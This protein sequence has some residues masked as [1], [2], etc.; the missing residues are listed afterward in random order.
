MPKKATTPIVTIS[1]HARDWRGIALAVSLDGAFLLHDVS[2][3]SVEGFIQAIRMRPYTVKRHKALRSLTMTAQTFAGNKQRTWVWWND[4]KV[5]YG[6]KKHHDYIERAFRARLLRCEHALR[7]LAASNSVTFVYRPRQNEA[8]VSLRPAHVV[9]IFS[10]LR[11]EVVA[12]GTLLPREA[13]QPK[14]R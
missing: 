2:P 3:A 12:T 1:C 10:K 9:A 7:A 6:S 13:R 8:R 4:K 5:R 11:D 14:T